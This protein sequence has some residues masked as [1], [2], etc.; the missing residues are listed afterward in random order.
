MRIIFFILSTNFRKISRNFVA[1]ERLKCGNFLFISFNLMKHAWRGEKFCFE[2]KFFIQFL[3]TSFYRKMCRNFKFRLI[4]FCRLN[5]ALQ[6]CCFDLKMI[7]SLYL[8][9]PLSEKLQNAPK[10]SGIFRIFTREVF[11]LC[12]YFHLYLW[13]FPLPENSYYP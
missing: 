8:C 11:Q 10:F 2:K 3:S 13:Q 9:A 5:S 1:E 7:L 4:L 6:R 12:S